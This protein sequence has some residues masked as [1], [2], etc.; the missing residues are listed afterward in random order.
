MRLTL[1][2]IGGGAY[3]YRIY[4]AGTG[5]AIAETLGHVGNFAIEGIG[6]PGHVYQMVFSGGFTHIPHTA[7]LEF[8]NEP[9]LG[10]LPCGSGT[11][12]TPP[13][14][15]PAPQPP[16][17]YPLP[18]TLT[19]TTI[20]DVCAALTALE[21]N[22]EHVKSSVDLLQ[23]YRLPFAYIPGAAH[24]QLSGSGSFFINGLVGLQVYVTTP[25]PSRPV[26]PGNPPYLFDCGW[27]SLNDAN[28]MLEEKRITRSG[29][30][31]I[32]EDA[33]LATSFNYALAA[34]VTIDVIEL[35]PEP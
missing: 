10:E 35:R 19:C 8:W 17:G 33:Q 25:P 5:T 15:P 23:R 21:R 11:T 1:T 32:A 34:G 31:W 14:P 18:P 26:L 27:M 4:Q 6:P 12:T 3:S 29:F 16:P 13:P 20:P 9:T 28:G 7:L 2:G 24:R 30:D 22:L